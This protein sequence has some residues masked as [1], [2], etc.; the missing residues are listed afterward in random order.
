[1]S[2]NQ[3]TVERSQTQAQ[4]LKQQSAP[5]KRNT[6]IVAVPETP[7]LQLLS[8]ALTREL[9]GDDQGLPHSGFITVHIQRSYQRS[10]GIDIL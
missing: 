8:S 6:F 3:I 9:R 10:P 5:I 1:M 2:L 7:L 4:G